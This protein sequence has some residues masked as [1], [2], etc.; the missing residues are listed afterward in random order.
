MQQDAADGVSANATSLIASAI[1]VVSD[2]DAIRAFSLKREFRRV[3]EDQYSAVAC[4]EAITRGLKMTRKDVSFIDTLVGEEAIGCLGIRPVLASHGYAFAYCVADLL[5][6]SAKSPAQP[7]V[8]K[9]ASRN[10]AVDPRSFAAAFAF[11]CH[12]APS[13]SI[14]VL[15]KESQLIHSIQ[16]IAKSVSATMPPKCG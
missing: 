13:E 12:E 14:R 2:A 1:D 3:V 8:R 11:S 6:Q 9:L 15:A 10:L 4:C 7:N 5:E 16:E